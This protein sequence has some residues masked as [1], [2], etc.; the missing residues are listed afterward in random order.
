[1]QAWRNPWFGPVASVA[2]ACAVAAPA[3]AQDAPDL[4]TR[5]ERTGFVETSRYTD[6]VATL[7]AIAA[8]TNAIVIDTFGYSLEGRALPVATWGAGPTRA[9]VFANIHAGEVAGKE[10]ALTLLRDLAAG[11]HDGW[12]DRLTL[13]VAPIYNADGNE[14]I[15]LTNRPLQ[16]GPVGG[17]G[18][19][20]NAMGLDLNRDFVKLESPEARSLVG[21]IDRFDPHVVVDL[22]TTNGTIHAYHLTYAPPLHP[23]T[24]PAIDRFSRETWLPEVTRALAE[25]PGPWLAYHYGNLPDA[26]VDGADDPA[27]ATGWYTYSPK[28]R[29]STNYIGLRNRFGILSEAYAYLPFEERVAVSLRFVEEVLDVAAERG[30][31]IRRIADAADGR[32]IVGDTLAVRA[33]EHRRVDESAEILLGAV[34][35]LA[36]PS[37]GR[38]MLVRRDEIR[39][40]R[41]P[42][43]SA[44]RPTAVE[45][46]PAAYLVP[47]SLGGVLDVLRAHG[48][49][50]RR[51]GRARALD[52][53]AFRID[54]ST[55]EEREFQGH[56]QRTL[57]GAW[58]PARL[59][60]EADAIVVPMDQ[61]LA[62]LAFVLLEPRS[63]D[64]LA[65]WNVLDESLE[66]AETYPVLRVN[67]PPP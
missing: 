8:T 15:A 22:H 7:E 40:E 19:R 64:G 46:V 25:G 13:A 39:R 4:R 59:D 11:L 10:A 44:F 57:E 5:A 43:Y 18:Q 29:F 16:H 26:G 31:E 9:L 62:R 35:T 61:P 14:R 48:I 32:R 1:M 12:R 37:T 24:D 34:D 28:P 47:S 54:A 67:E 6:V 30:E 53:E 27:G 45:R 58:E 63:D 38:P 23:N 42:E 2:M 55:L 50:T 41:M 21:L 36:H 56:R 17:M 65:S 3:L 60:V 52:V 49:E 33:A 66:G 20:P 51:L